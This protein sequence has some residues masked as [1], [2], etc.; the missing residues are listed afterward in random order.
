MKKTF[1]E[2]WNNFLDWLENCAEIML[3]IFMVVGTIIAKIV[4]DVYFR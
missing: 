3:V 2:R 1:R 4:Y